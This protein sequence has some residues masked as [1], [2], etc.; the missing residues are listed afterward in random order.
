MADGESWQDP[1]N[2]CVT[3]TCRVSW[4]RE[5]GGWRNLQTDKGK[6]LRTLD[7]GI[8]GLGGNYKKAAPLGERAEVLLCEGKQLKVISPPT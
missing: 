5:G 8:W 6:G 3:C 4:G 1:S 7:Q 2:A